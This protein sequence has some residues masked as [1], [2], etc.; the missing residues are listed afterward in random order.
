MNRGIHYIC[1]LM[2]EFIQTNESIFT[3]NSLIL[4]FKKILKEKILKINPKI[5]FN[6]RQFSKQFPKEI[7]LHN[8]QTRN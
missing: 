3:F 4:F 1:I 5:S 6:F 8:L 7:L 2:K